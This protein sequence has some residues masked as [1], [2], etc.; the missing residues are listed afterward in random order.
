MTFEFS[1][2][3][4]R[5]GRLGVRLAQGPLVP[6]Q[7]PLVQGPGLLPLPHVP[8]VRVRVRVRVIFFFLVRVR[9]RVPF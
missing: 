4:G 6:P 9:V 8:R 7:R 5:V 2:Q 1:Q 3:T